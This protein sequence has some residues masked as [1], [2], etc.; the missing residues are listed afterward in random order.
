[1]GTG[2][3]KVYLSSFLTEKDIVFEQTVPSVFN[4]V[5]ALVTRLAGNHFPD[6]A[7][8][9]II[10]A[11]LRRERSAPTIVGNGVAMPHARIEGISRPYMALGIYPAGVSMVEGEPPVHLVCLLLIPESQPAR[12]LQILRSLSSLLQMPNAVKRIAAMTQAEEVM[13]FMLRS[14]L[15]LPD[16]IC[17]GDLMTTNLE[18]MREME[19]LSK[20][21]DLLMEHERAEIPIVDEAGHLLGAVGTQ[22]LL[23]TFIPKGL[24]KLM[25]VLFTKEGPYS[26]EKLAEILHVA[27]RTP[28]RDAMETKVCICHIDTPAREVAV[29]LG[30]H[31]AIKCYVLDNEKKLVGVITLAEFFRRILKD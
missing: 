23:T 4:L 3:S 1:M 12:Y 15:K 29:D 26:G 14:E 20:A 5:S 8:D 2:D 17:A 6:I 7:V 24:R 11:V 27:H 10:D 22:A 16:Y 25:P 9:P 18:T 21:L 28:V 13:Q 30:E 31:N 19:P